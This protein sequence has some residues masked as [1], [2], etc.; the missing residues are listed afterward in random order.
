MIN[1]CPYCGRK[2]DAMN[3]TLTKLHSD[4][5]LFHKVCL[6][7]MWQKANNQKQKAQQ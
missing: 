2:Q 5:D 3:K 7:K 6:K 4:S 1:R